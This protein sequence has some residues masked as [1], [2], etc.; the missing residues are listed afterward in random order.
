MKTDSMSSKR[1]QFGFTLIELIVVIIILGI[2]A[3]VALPRFVNLQREARIAKLQAAR[4]SILAGSALAHATVL[5]RAGVA[6]AAGCPGGGGTATNI[7][8]GAGTVCTESG[9]VSLTNGYPAVSAIGT[10][11]ILSMAGLTSA[12]IPTAAN[13][14]ADGYTYAVAGTTATFGVV[15]A[16]TAGTCFFSY[17]AAIANAAPVT[18][19]D[20]AGC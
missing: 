2:L 8:T 17:T 6:D 12:F 16:T 20:T 15:G 19:S 13:L 18:A 14:Q 1:G 9:I 11:G 10:A 3:S 4:G 5:A 7:T